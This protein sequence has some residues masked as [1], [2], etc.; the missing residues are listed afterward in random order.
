MRIMSPDSACAGKDFFETSQLQV[1]DIEKPVI[2]RS[3]EGIQRPGITIETLHCHG[4][5]ATM[6][7]LMLLDP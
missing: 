4:Y 3:H 1:V 7:F 2:T 5:G 6:L